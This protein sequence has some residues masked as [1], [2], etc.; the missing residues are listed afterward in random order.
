MKKLTALLS[1]LLILLFVHSHMADK[2]YEV[3]DYAQDFKLQATDGKMISLTDY[4]EAKG[5]VV[6]FTC[7]GCPYAQAYQ[8]RINEI[9]E[10]YAAKGYPVIAINPNSTEQNAGESLEQM[11]KRA[12]EQGYTFPYLQDETQEITRTYG[13]TNTPHVYILKKEGK[14]KY[15]VAYMGTIDNNFR[16]A[17]QASKHYVEAALDALLAKQPVPETQTKAIGCSIKFQISINFPARVLRGLFLLSL[18]HEIWHNSFSR[19]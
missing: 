15:Q 14:E 11:K 2:G 6:V 10:K 19:F 7:N 1:I 12:Q 17:S 18:P 16:D 3:G 13:A 5:F 8:G 9:N 4:P